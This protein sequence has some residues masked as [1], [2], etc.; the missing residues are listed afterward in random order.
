MVIT[1]LGSLRIHEIFMTALNY[2][3]G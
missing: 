1:D 2:V 3:L